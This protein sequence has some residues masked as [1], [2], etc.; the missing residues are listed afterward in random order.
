MFD[1]E[2][3]RPEI[4]RRFEHETPQWFADA[5]LGIFI[6]WGPYSVPA[7]AEPTGELGTI[8]LH[9]WMKHNP[10]AEWYA[11]TIR[12]DGSPAQ[13]HH[14]EAYG[15][16]DYY[17]FLD[18]WDAS[19]FD[20][21][22]LMALFA[23]AGARYFVPTTKHHDGVTLWNAPG[24][25]ELNTVVRGPKRDLV[26][27]FADAARGAAL[28]FGAYYSGGLDWSF[29]ELPAI[30]DDIRD[31]EDGRP[32]RPTDAAYAE[33][34]F[35]HVIDL[36]DKYQPDVLWGDIEWPDAGKPDGP[37]SL[38]K[39]FDRFYAAAPEG[40]INDRFGQTHWDYETSEY[41]VNLAAEDATVWE[42]C[43]GVGYSFGGKF[44]LNV[45]LKADGT[46]P[47]LQRETLTAMGDWNTVN[48]SAV[49]GSTT[50]DAAIAG[51]SNDPWIRWTRTG[52][53]AHAFVDAVGSVKLPVYA[54]A[55]DLN[56][57]TLGGSPIEAIGSTGGVRVTLPKS[58]IPGP[59]VV[60]FRITGS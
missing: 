33:Y 10:Y 25:P 16:A 59:S 47:E 40:V 56:S 46:L 54:N 19:L 39:M 44:L 15:G 58:A 21:D 18:A 51:A 3:E 42:N 8:E 7:W 45:G 31:P 11:N 38:V 20:P 32:R 12:I 17:D 23:K 6:H 24:N 1:D 57:A 28:K 60:S 53:L 34:A 27:L 22:E 26:K 9:E 35:N 41:Q 30:T 29:E 5:K 52:S 43:R 48:G 4:Y 13:H 2:D 50:L 49:H 37:F 14:Q 55:L 36:I